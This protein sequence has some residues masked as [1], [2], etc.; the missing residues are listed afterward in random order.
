[1]VKTRS[2]SEAETSPRESKKSKQEPLTPIPPTP[3]RQ[4][5]ISTASLSPEDPEI[6]TLLNEFLQT[7]TGPIAPIATA[8]RDGIASSK[9]G[10]SSLD[11]VRRPT[12][13]WTS[14]MLLKP[15]IL[16]SETTWELMPPSYEVFVNELISSYTKSSIN[17]YTVGKPLEPAG[18]DAFVRCIWQLQE[19]DPECTYYAINIPTDTAKMK[20][21]DWLKITGVPYG[22]QM[23]TTNITPR[24]TFVD[25]H[26][27]HGRHGITTVFGPCI[28]LWALYPPTPH[29]LSLYSSAV[30]SSTPFTSLSPQLEGGE[31]C[32]TTLKDTLYL[33]PGCLHATYT[34]RGGLTPGFE[35]TTGDCLE[36]GAQILAINKRR[37]RL[38]PGDYEPFLEAVVSAFR[39]GV[40]ES[41]EAERKLCVFYKVVAKQKGK[42][43]AEIRKLTKGRP[44]KGCGRMWKAHL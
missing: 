39:G 21:P 18:D 19:P 15:L 24:H 22:K 27:D 40:K 20:L 32:I 29:N 16:P 28:K 31:F 23:T 11:I 8:F 10:I 13:L 5:K 37:F 34:L 3:P 12:H 9:N 44:C 7:S 26:I 6:S 14:L 17:V 38:G 4:K 35:Y 2:K 41:E 43:A 25:L 33:P 30:A 36:V 1:M 42:V